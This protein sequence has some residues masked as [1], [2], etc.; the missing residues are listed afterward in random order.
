M[1]LELI[2]AERRN[3]TVLRSYPAPGAR[4]AFRIMQQIQC[5]D[6]ESRDQPLFGAQGL[7][8]V[9]TICHDELCKPVKR[10]RKLRFSEC[11]FVEK[12]IEYFY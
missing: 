1:C 4:T 5:I 11:R 8:D 10:F 3:T 7:V 12:S 9:D 2:R 6:A